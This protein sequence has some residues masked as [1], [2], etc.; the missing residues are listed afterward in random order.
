MTDRINFILYN[1]R[2]YFW[3]FKSFQSLPLHQKLVK[4]KIGDYIEEYKDGKE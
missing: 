3:L 1:L 4:M 2:I